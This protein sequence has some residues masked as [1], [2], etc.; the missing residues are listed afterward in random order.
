MGDARRRQTA[1]WCCAEHVSPDLQQSCC[2]RSY[3]ALRGALNKG[4]LLA[5]THERLAPA[6]AEINGCNYCLSGH[7]YLGKKLA[8]LDDAAI[9]ANRS[10]ASNDPK[11]DAAVRFAAKIVRDRGHLA[12]MISKPSTPLAMTTRG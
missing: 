4:A 7:T 6:V 8:K 10:G 3:L 5:A 9:A 11:A 2:A 1:T 12:W